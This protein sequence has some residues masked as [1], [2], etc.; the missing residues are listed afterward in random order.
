MILECPNRHC[1]RTLDLIPVIVETK[2][3]TFT[4]SWVNFIQLVFCTL[5]PFILP[6]LGNVEL[7]LAIKLQPKYQSL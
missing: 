5:I 1:G 4:Q 6:F 3:A 2:D 7:L